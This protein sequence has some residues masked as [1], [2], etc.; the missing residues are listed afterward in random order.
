MFG[1]IDSLV[2]KIE[3]LANGYDLIHCHDKYSLLAVNVLIE[4]GHVDLKKVKIILTQHAPFYDQF[5]I[6][7]ESDYMLRS[8]SRALDSGSTYSLSSLIGV[9]NLQ[10]ELH[11]DGHRSLYA[12]TVKA[13]PNCVD[14]EYDSVERLPNNYLSGIILVARQLHRKNGVIIALKAVNLVRHYFTKH[15]LKLIILGEGPERSSLQSFVRE[16]NLSDIV[17]LRGMVSNREV[18]DLMSN[19]F[20][21]LLPSVPVGRYIEATSISMLESMSAGIPVIGSNIG[22]IAE[23]IE[24]EKSGVLF[25]P[26]D[27]E[28][29]AEIIVKLKENQ[30]LYDSLRIG[31]YKRILEN[32]SMEK[33]TSK[34][35]NFYQS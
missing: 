18:R 25:N 1:M 14:L 23:V 30:D 15:N 6:T 22:G 35:L 13:L 19:A 10:C 8:I 5:I 21:S 12:H 26:G 17:E 11:T 32:Y 28:R 7:N 9:D 3:P 34:L 2:R 27:Y 31:G 29:L 4:S 16:N 20:C 24:N 33:W